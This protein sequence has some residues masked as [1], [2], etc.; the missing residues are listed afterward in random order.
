MSTLPLNR[1]VVEAGSFDDITA[2][3]LALYAYNVGRRFFPGRPHLVEEAVQETL[4]RTCE[5]WSKAT[6]YGKAEAWVV[7]TATN[8]CHE[9]LREETRGA[10]PSRDD[11]VQ[12]DGGDDVVRRALLADALRRLSTRQRL[13]VVWR[14]VFDRSVVQTASELGLTESKVRDA[15]HN[16]VER[17]QRL[18]GEQWNEMP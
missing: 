14:Y 11:D 7:N 8:V 16:G 1:D 4:T 6:R 5:H 17:L 12:V 9:K 3:R 18:L 10:R 15:T 2:T 13:V